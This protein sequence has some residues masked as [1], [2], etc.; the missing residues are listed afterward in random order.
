MGEE[1]EVSE[2]ELFD[3]VY[4]FDHTIAEWML[5]RLK[6]FMTRTDSTPAK[7][8]ENGQRMK[9]EDGEFMFLEMEEWQKILQDMV[10]GFE[11]YVKDDYAIKDQSKVKR[12]LELFS[13]YFFDLWL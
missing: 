9:D 4:N 10:D 5:P 8:D 6:F 11:Q 13:Q 1:R 3:D 7:L 12:A 2:D